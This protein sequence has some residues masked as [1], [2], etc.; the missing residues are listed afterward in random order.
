MTDILNRE[1]IDSLREMG[2]DFFSELIQTFLD[3]SR[4]ETE[5]IRRGIE[6]ASGP[7]VE[8]AAHCLKGACLGQGAEEMAGICRELERQ[9][10]EGDLSEAAKTLDDLERSFRRTEEDLSRLLPGK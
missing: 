2:D 9:G 6:A 5:R 8:K 7:K 10:E 4:E 3:S 1:T